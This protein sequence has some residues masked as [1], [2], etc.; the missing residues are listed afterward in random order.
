MKKK[1]AILINVLLAALLGLAAANLLAQAPTAGAPTPTATPE[2]ADPWEQWVREYYKVLVVPKGTEMRLG[3]NLAR[4]HPRVNAVM[5]ILDEDDQ[6]VYLRHLPLEDPRSAGHKAWLVR[7]GR[8]VQQAER[9]EAFKKQYVIVTGGAPVPPPFTQRL[10]FVDRSQGLPVEGLWQMGFALADVNRDGQVDLALP[11][12]RKGEA[13]PWVYLQTDQGWREWVE[14]RWPDEP[15]FDYGDVEVADFDGDGNLDIAIACH[16]KRS[17]V[18][19]GDGNGSFRR[20][21]ELPVGNKAVTSRALAVADFNGDGRKDIVLLAELDID[22]TTSQAITSGLINVVLNTPE[23]WKLSP[24]TFPR[25][26]Y[27]DHVAVGDFDGNGYPDILTASHKAGNPFYVFLNE[28]KGRSFK[29]YVS[30]AFPAQSFILG[31]ASGSLDG[32]KPDQIILAVYQSL[33]PKEGEHHF[34]HALLAY[35]LAEKPGK[36]LPEPK[37]TVI[38]VDQEGPIN[39]FRDVALGDLDGDGRA[40][41]VGLRA[42]GELL[43]LLQKPDGGF[44]L[45]RERVGIPEASPSSVVVSKVGSKTLLVANFS[46]NGKAKGGVKVWEVEAARW[47]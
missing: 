7:Q 26:I 25:G 21:V 44:L 37:R 20:W 27:G 40:D 10:R 3:G 35:R 8:E 31:V 30:D 43:I 5:E 4:P 46:D 6:F 19:Y 2:T 29:P 39:S 36:L 41:V 24:A 18:L 22:L 23:G 12:A 17:Y 1:E 28:D 16:F 9:E 38:Y 42:N 13:H 45:E 33:R 14:A 15:S 34:S 11:P 47:K 32:K